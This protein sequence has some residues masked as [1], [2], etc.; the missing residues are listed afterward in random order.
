[1]V[2]EHCISRPVNVSPLVLIDLLVA[3]HPVSIE[4]QE[5]WSPLEHIEA[6]VG[7]LVIKSW[8]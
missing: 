7:Q 6:V 3:D 1:M 2:R 8:W 4:K 5:D